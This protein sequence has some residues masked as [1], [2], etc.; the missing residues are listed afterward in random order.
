MDVGEAGRLYTR[1]D[2]PAFF[3]VAAQ[4]LGIDTDRRA[5]W[6]FGMD[7]A[8][9]YCVITPVLCW[10]LGLAWPR[11]CHANYFYL[12]DGEKFSTSR[13]HLMGVAHA[14]ERLG[15][16]WL[17]VH[18]AETRPEL[19]ETDFTLE[20][21]AKAIEVRRNRWY[22]FVRAVAER[23]QLAGDGVTVEAGVWNPRHIAAFNALDD[24]RRA[25]GRAADPDC[26]SLPAL[27]AALEATVQLATELRAAEPGAAGTETFDAQERTTIALELAAARQ[28]AVLLAPLA[29]NV[30]AGISRAIGLDTDPTST[31]WSRAL[32]FV[33]A[34]QPLPAASVL[35][36][37]D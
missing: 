8:F 3:T 16:D 25:A 29:P 5:V 14:V 7:N 28:L 2:E 27:V 36:A 1:G 30:A 13:R 32:E 24:Q 23:C 9:L 33:P 10:A 11:A 22:G 19:A 4:R 12:L 6:L 21:A 17:R 20:G 35:D 37:L 31:P 26:F 15:R 18:L 34:G